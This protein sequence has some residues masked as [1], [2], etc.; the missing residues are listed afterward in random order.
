MK[1]YIMAYTEE[2]LDEIFAKAMKI[3]NTN[4]KEVGKDC[5]EAIIKRDK[6]GEDN[7]VDEFYWEVDHIYPKSKAEEKKF[8]N[9]LIN[10]MINLRPLHGENN[11]TEGKGDDYP[12]YKSAVTSKGERN[13]PE[14][15][16]CMVNDVT[17]NRLDNHFGEQLD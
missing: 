2:Q 8:P 7:R 4:D 16:N 10:D 3:P 6:Y 15:R 17:Q 9:E 11:G 14:V 12:K 13:I 1:L 5:C